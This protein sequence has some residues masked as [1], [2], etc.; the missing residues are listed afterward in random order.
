MGK[1]ATTNLIMYNYNNMESLYDEDL[2]YEFFQ[3][4]LDKNYEIA[5]YDGMKLNGVDFRRLL[6][7]LSKQIQVT[8]K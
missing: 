5:G 6:L 4:H 2:T 8:Q 3:E 7:L 1:K